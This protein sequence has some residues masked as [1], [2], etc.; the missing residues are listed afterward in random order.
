M[1]AAVLHALSFAAGLWVSMICPAGFDATETPVWL[2]LRAPHAGHAQTGSGW[3]SYARPED[4]GEIIRAVVNQWRFPKANDPTRFAI[5]SAILANATGFVEQRLVTAFAA[6]EHAS[7]TMEVLDRGLDDAR[8]FGLSG[9][10]RVRR[11]LIALDVDPA[12]NST[13]NSRRLS[14]YGRSLGYY[15]LAETVVQVRNTV[16][17]PKPGH[18]LYAHEGVLL[19]ALHHVHFWLELAIL[20]RLNYTG[21]VSNRTLPMRDGGVSES[22]PWTRRTSPAA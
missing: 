15:D 7:W 4:L 19:D 22:V 18:D 2:N 6:L 11:L 5:T 12:F 3:W 8:W 20:C 13:V 9:K 10:R 14:D 1:L 17:H 21:E 16:A